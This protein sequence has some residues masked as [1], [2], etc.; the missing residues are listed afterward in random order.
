MDGHAVTRTAFKRPVVCSLWGAGVTLEWQVDRHL[1]LTQ[2]YGHC[3][4]GP[5]F[6]RRK[7][8]ARI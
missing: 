6:E 7:H 3:F 4:A 5:F 8:S 1:T 2:E